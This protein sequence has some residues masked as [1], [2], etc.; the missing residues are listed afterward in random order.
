MS[1][2]GRRSFF[3]HAAPGETAFGADTIVEIGSIT[4]VFTTALLAEAFAEGKLR[5]DEPLSSMTPGRNFAPCTGRSRRCNRPISRPACRNCRATFRRR[6]AER[7]IDHYTGRTSSPGSRASTR[8]AARAAILPAPYRYSNA[9]VGLLGY[10]LADRLGERWE[11]LVR[12]RITEPLG[13]ASTSV[14][15]PPER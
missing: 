10:I 12:R 6:L 2:Q 11:E 15:V 13:M 4:K 9:S 3:G 5:P 1:W 8:I 7:G 14:R